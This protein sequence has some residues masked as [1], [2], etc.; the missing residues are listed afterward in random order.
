MQ[1][2][3]LNGTFY[4]H[5]QLRYNLA[6]LSSW[7]PINIRKYFLSTRCWSTNM[8]NPPR[9]KTL[10]S[11]LYRWMRIGLHKFEHQT[12]QATWHA[13]TLPC[14]KPWQFSPSICSLNDHDSL[15][16]KVAYHMYVHRENI[17]VCHTQGNKKFLKTN[18]TSRNKRNIYYDMSWDHLYELVL[19]N[20][21][22][23]I[24]DKFYSLYLDLHARHIQTFGHYVYI[25]T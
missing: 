8:V 10:H 23:T 9:A 4:L 18:M 14:I 2:S 15:V 13:I 22:G 7:V 17:L 24:V 21:T 5:K 16:P 1:N 3:N 19:F 12:W 25:H 11:D 6:Q 20:K